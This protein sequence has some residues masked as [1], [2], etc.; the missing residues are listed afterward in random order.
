MR[1]GGQNSACPPDY[2]CLRE[3]IAHLQ[4]ALTIAER[5][6][7]QHLIATWVNNLGLAYA[8]ANRREEALQH[9]TR[10]LRMHSAAGDRRAEG[11]TLGNLANLLADHQ[12]ASKADDRDSGG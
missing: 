8:L 10:A 7:D 9:F 11:L 3:G 5:E 2:L 4:A 12:D 6:D 1:R